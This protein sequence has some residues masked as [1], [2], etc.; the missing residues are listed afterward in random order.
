MKTIIS[1]YSKFIKTIDKK[2]DRS[3]RDLIIRTWVG[4]QEIERN[5]QIAEMLREMVGEDNKWE[6]VYL[7]AD[8]EDDDDEQFL[9]KTEKEADEFLDKRLFNCPIHTGNKGKERCPSCDAEWGVY[10]YKDLKRKRIIKIAA[11]Y[12][13][14]LE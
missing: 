12:G 8:D 9:F 6:A 3:S 11:K 7:P 1:K 10:P 5:K 13:F 4:L 14:N 2:H